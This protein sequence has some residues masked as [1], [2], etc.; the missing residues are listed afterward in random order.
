[1]AA[2]GSQKLAIS[3]PANYAGYTLQERTNL[4]SGSWIT[5][6]TGTNNPAVITN[7]VAHKY[8]RLYQAA[9]PTVAAAIPATSQPPAATARV[10]RILKLQP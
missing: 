10:L 6:A 2:S 3:W 7:N 9:A 4:M 8:Y 5:S 1:M